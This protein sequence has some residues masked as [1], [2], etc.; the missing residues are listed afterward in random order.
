MKK[1]TTAITIALAAVLAASPAVLAACSGDHY[2][3][4]KFPAQDT[5]YAVTSQGGSAVAY[6]N[7]V[8]FINGTRGYDDTDGKANVWD[9]VVKGAL[10]RAEFNGAKYTDNDGIVRFERTLD[11]E[12]LEFKYKKGKDY[13]DN[14]INVVDAT[15][16]APKTIGTSGYSDGGI[17]IYDNNVYFAT[18][19][20]EK[21]K[22]GTVQ[23]TRTDFFTVPLGGGKP[24][25]IYTTTEK[26][27][28]TSSAYAFY[29]FKGCVYLV[30][31]EGS[32]IVSV[33]YDPSKGKADDAKYFKV[34]ATKVLF[35]VRDT[36]YKGI[37]NNTVEDFIYFIRPRTD[38][39]KAKSGTVIEAMRPDGSENFKVSMNGET[40]ELVAVRNGLLFYNSNY[41]GKKYTHYNNL[42]NALMTHSPTYKAAQEKSGDAANSQISGRFSAEMSG[43]ITAS[44]PFRADESSNV[45][46]LVAATGSGLTL[47]VNDVNDP[48]AAQLCSTTGTPLFI[49]N[50]YL[51]FSGSS[52]DFYRVPLFANLDGFGEAQ[53]LAQNTG[54][55]GISCD[56]VEGYFTYFAEVDQWANNYTYFY[57]VDGIEGMEPQFVGTR[58]SSDI[59]SKKQIEE[60][61]GTSD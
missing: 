26:V 46:Y 25:K 19:D 27:D 2:S 52:S 9:E 32:D 4:M 45:V 36:Y 23:T 55:A 15:K 34:G 37:D 13:Y 57:L 29:K 35:P 56:Y 59:P 17:F 22:T 61:L 7:Y 18:P 8:Y 30:V 21:N 11:D 24:V 60:S 33:K 58:A 42:H 40:E 10:Y 50:N 1:R 16:I 12:G 39:D 48:I 5:S 43:S 41:A 38:D 20:N 49:K 14:E 28:T 44:Y 3:E 54:S 47:Y 6:G 31:N 53:T 51:Y